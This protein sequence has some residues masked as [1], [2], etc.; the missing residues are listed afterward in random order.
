MKTEYVL[1]VE[2]SDPPLCFDAFN[3]TLEEAEARLLEVAL[4]YFG[5]IATQGNNDVLVGLQDMGVDVSIV[6][7]IDGRGVAYIVPFARPVVERR[8][9]ML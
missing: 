5:C 3:D 8:P 2:A 1:S 7:E 6:K 9:R 4:D